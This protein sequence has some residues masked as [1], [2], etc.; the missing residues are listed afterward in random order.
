MSLCS[1]IHS[2]G[3]RS[4]TYEEG[5]F[6]CVPAFLRY[7]QQCIACVRYKFNCEHYCEEL[8]IVVFS[9]SVPLEHTFTTTCQIS[10]TSPEI[11]TYLPTKHKLFVNTTG[12]IFIITSTAHDCKTKCYTASILKCMSFFAPIYK[13]NIG[14]RYFAVA[15]ST[16]RRTLSDKVKSAIL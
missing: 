16:L 10:H 1:I 11:Y 3:Q 15:A 13:S 6:L 14:S 7:S 8:V 12:L 5:S 9:R 2:C 4:Q